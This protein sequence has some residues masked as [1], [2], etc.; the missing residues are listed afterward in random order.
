MTL[1]LATK[2]RRPASPKKYIGRTELVQRLNAGLGANHQVFLVSAPAGFGKTTCVSEWVNSLKQFQVAWLSLDSADD[3]PGRFFAYLLASLQ[4][5]NE[6]IGHEIAGTL[7]AGQLPPAEVISTILINDILEFEREFFLVLDDFHLLQ[8]GFILAFLE[9]LLAN[10]PPGLRLILITREDPPLPLA[11]LRANNCLTEIRAKDLR[12]KKE[13]IER[14]LR[15][16]MGLSISP[17][18]IN[19]LEDKTEG[20]IAGL[21]LAGLSLR[22]QEDPSDFIANLRGSHR[23]ILAYLTE[24]VLDRQPEEIRD[25]L[26]QTSILDKLNR[27]LCN[28]VT[29]HPD[30]HLR[31]ERLLNANLFLIPL[32][33]E[34]HWYR[35]H[36]L[37]AD[38]LRNLQDRQ[39]QNLCALL[40]R[41]SQ[42]Y[43]Q[44]GMTNEAIQ[45]ALA[46]EDYPFAVNLLE[47]HAL[48][49]V[50]QGYAKTVNGWV[51]NLP[52]EWGLQSPRANLALAWTHLLRGAYSQAHPYLERLEGFFSSFQDNEKE[53]QSLRAEWLV[54]RSLLL[55]MEGRPMES[56]TLVKEALAI[57]P[58]E[59]Y[60]VR[61]L[62]QF[63]LATTY[64]ATADNQRA[65]DAYQTAL[66][67]SRDAGN[68]IVEMLSTSGLAQMAF[69]HGQ[70]HRAYEIAAPAR[71]QIERSDSL[72]PI[73][74][75]VFG[76][77]GEVSYQWYQTEQ[78]RQ[79]YERA[80]Q[81][82]RLGGYNSG[83][84]GCRVF[85]SRLFQLQGDL[86]SA[87]REIQIAINL[88]KVDTPE[89]VR[90][91]AIS[92]QVRVYLARG[93]FSS[94]EMALQAQ[95]FS[96]EGRFSYPEL[97][98]G[99]SI[100]YSAGLL[101]N[102]S[103]WFLLYQARARSD[104]S[105][106]RSGI[107]LA[108]QLVS[109]AR[110]GLSLL[111]ALE[112][113]LLRA[114]MH[115]MLGEHTASQAD[116]NKALELGEPEGILG[117]FLEHG[118]PV[119]ETLTEM[120]KRKQLGDIQ[121]E[122]AKHILD[123]FSARRSLDE[124]PAAVSSVGTGPETL[125]EP[126]TEREIEVLRLMADGLKYKEIAAKL[127]ISHNTVRF[128]VK[129]IYGKLSVN[130]RTL[131]I[132]KGRQ[133][134]IL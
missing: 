82:S 116:Y 107:G 77:L 63:G 60:R 80:L 13:D 62:A 131:A 114:Q 25:F 87:G 134:Q 53:R 102:S 94:A 109:R 7:R 50:M 73:S 34:G 54:M 22:E 106:L 18:D 71:A 16:V 96:F 122:Y 120:V 81:L 132:E 59:D 35:C 47:A 103:L 61:S 91:E 31:L 2:L 46:A 124:G 4:T 27:E 39:K 41:A 93:Q 78:A 69:E 68:A 83:A 88:M 90:K 92:Q 130:N 64:R 74:T 72:P 37:F 117:V 15:E 8:E 100:D 105:R 44:A 14:F 19:I 125:I 110:A 98:P 26:L 20:W 112:T 29:D 51:Q 76:I 95:G 75:V 33:D 126:L 57:I 48:D 86:E 66:Q 56:M 45:H 1:L 24:Q 9:T 70:L 38:L 79:Y 11:Q 36:H 5:V 123:A 55:N 67:F 104:T 99:L 52:A 12:F 49:M 89:Y 118:Q 133:L 101:C 30:S 65:A 17:S 40:Q 21:Q 97:A 115:A 127:F 121:L 58:A 3:D 6:H 10:L 43:I 84:V 85:F 108:D 42:W 23:H 32:D 129:A 28:A 128:H 113:L 111:V 119:A